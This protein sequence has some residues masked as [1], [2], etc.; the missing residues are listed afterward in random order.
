[1]T[2]QAFIAK[3]GPGGPGHALNERQGAQ[4]HFNELC[5]LLG[6]ASPT[7]SN[8]G[9]SDYLFEKGTLAL[10]GND[11]QRRGFADVFKRG[12]FAWEYKAS[13]RPLDAALSQLMR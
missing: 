1:M 8:D 6:V 12:C 4:Q 13:G 10:G 9:Q 7:G 3:W 5:A 11:T 2:P